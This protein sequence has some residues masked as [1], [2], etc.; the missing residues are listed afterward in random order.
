MILST[1]IYIEYFKIFFTSQNMLIITDL[2]KIVCSICTFP[3][4][5]LHTYVTRARYR[6]LFAQPQLGQYW[7]N[8]RE[9]YINRELVN[10]RFVP[11]LDKVNSRVP[12][13]FYLRNAASV[14]LYDDISINHIK[15]HYIFN[16]ILILVIFFYFF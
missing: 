11:N 15:N 14:F 5:K 7:I 1:K 12:K 6:Q 16:K 4:R 3:H 9:W 13:A 10:P 8:F 2:E